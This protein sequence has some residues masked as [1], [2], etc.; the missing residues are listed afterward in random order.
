M[1]RTG[2]SVDSWW[3][4][5]KRIV[6]SCFV[7]L[8]NNKAANDVLNVVMKTLD[9]PWEC[10]RLWHCDLDDVILVSERTGLFFCGIPPLLVWFSFLHRLFSFCSR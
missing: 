1:R 6:P 4:S 5:P 2:S 8:A 7:S 10:Y 3:I 9:F